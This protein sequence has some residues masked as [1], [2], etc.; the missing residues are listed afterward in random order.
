MQSKQVCKLSALSEINVRKIQ[1]NTWSHGPCNNLAIIK[2][3][4]KVISC[5]QKANPSRTHTHMCCSL[6]LAFSVRFRTC[7][8]DDV[9]WNWR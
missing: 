8:L 3:L 6:R 2:F 7:N 9:K 5:T 1:I 4:A